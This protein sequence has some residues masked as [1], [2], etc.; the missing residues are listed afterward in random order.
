MMRTNMFRRILALLLLATLAS[1]LLGVAAM[2]E[3]TDKKPPFV[4]SFIA[5]EPNTYVTTAIQLPASDCNKLVIEAKLL[6]TK[7]ADVVQAFAYKLIEVKT[8]EAGTDKDGKTLYQPDDPEYIW[9]EGMRSWLKADEIYKK[10]I[11]SDN[12]SVTPEFAEITKEDAVTFFGKI[13]AAIEDGTITGLEEATGKGKISA[14]VTG[15]FENLTMGEYLIVIKDVNSVYQSTVVAVDPFSVSYKPS[16]T[17]PEEKIWCTNGKTVIT[18][19]G[20]PVS[21]DKSIANTKTVQKETKPGKE[22]E[23]ET[24]VESYTKD[25]SASFGDKVSYRVVSLIPAYL[26]E[27]TSW[28]YEIKDEMTNLT[29]IQDSIKIMLD[30]VT[31]ITAVIREKNLMT[32]SAT[33]FEIKFGGNDY[34]EILK[35]KGKVTVTYDARLNFD[36]ALV[37]GNPNTVTLTYSNNPYV[38]DQSTTR[39]DEN[40]VFT[41]GVEVTKYMR[42]GPKDELLKD[43]EFKLLDAEGEEIHVRQM[44][45]S[46]YRVDPDGEDVLTSDED[47]MLT[48]IGLG[49]G[50]YTLRETK[51]PEPELNQNP[52]PVKITLKGAVDAA[53][54][55]T[56]SVDSGLGEKPEALE[57]PEEPEVDEKG[58]VNP[59]AK[60]K[61]EADLAA[62]EKREAERAEW[63]RKHAIEVK[64][65]YPLTI[66]NTPPPAARTG[67]LGTA[68]F[69]ML[70]ILLMAAGAALVVT[71]LRRRGTQV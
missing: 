48:I 17:A 10:Y 30:D 26:D 29:L 50:E 14:D 38:I 71:V 63:D 5:D 32:S 24:V 62:Y 68:P 33:Q 25:A 18:M 42:L 21:V 51:V 70:G 57:K 66:V 64:G 39:T 43:V 9:A 7:D 31:D 13:E 61:Y 16:A 34:K 65:L 12:N 37:K 40:K 47:G 45:G 67:G 27:M 60:A 44:T 53:G 36:A 6:D 3:P 11:N 1:S 41:Y 4:D 55:R 2:A 35:G 8:V 56:G 69:T 54:R 58:Q 23:Y 19:K 46:T 20:T 15:R 28:R 59:V 49:E 52:P 22:P